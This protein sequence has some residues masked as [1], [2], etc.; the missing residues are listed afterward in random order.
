MDL[1]EDEKGLERKRFGQSP[2]GFLAYQ[3]FHLRFPLLVM[4]VLITIGLSYSATNLRVG[5]GF[6]KMV[7]VNHE[8]MS[9]YFK[10]R[11]IFG[12]ANKIQVAVVARDDN[13]FTAEFFE[14]LKGV[15]EEIFY[16]PG[17]S[18]TTVTSLY[19]PN[20]LFLEVVE[21]GFRAERL[22]TNKFKPTQEH[23]DTLKNKVAKS[24]WHGRIVAKDFSGAMV[25]AS[26]LETNPETGEPLDPQEISEI[27]EQIR[28]KYENENLSVH[29]IGF[30]KSIGDIAKGAEGVVAFFA[31]A[32]LITALLL[33]WYSGS[34]MLAWWALVCAMVPVVWLLGILPLLDMV[35]DPMSILVPFLIFSIGVSHAVQMTNAWKLETLHG[36][37]GV[38]ASRN[39]FMKLFIPGALALLANALGFMVIAVVDIQI[40]RELVFTATIGVSLMILTNK[41]L[42]PIL[43]SYMKINA[44]QAQKMTGKESALDWLWEK[45]GPIVVRGPVPIFIIVGGILV[46]M[47]GLWKAQDLHI[48]DLGQG[49]PELRPEARYNQDVEAITSRFTTGIDVLQI[50]P[51]AKG[52]DES[53]CLQQEVMDTLDRFEFQMRQYDGVQSVRG[54]ASFA[55]SV[56]QA[57]SE[58]NLKWRVM[59]DNAPQIAQ[60]IA[61]ST[62]IG[63][64]LFDKKCESLVVSIYTD[65]H[66]ATTIEELVGHVKAFKQANDSELIEFQLASG[67]VGVMAATNE[68]V[69]ASDKWVNLAL[70]V[71]VALLCLLEFKSIRIVVAIVLPLGI[72][73]LLCNALMAALDIGL[74]VNT[75]PVVALGVG[76]GVDYG[77]YLFSVIKHEIEERGRSLQE[78]FVMSLKQRGMSSLFTAVMMTVSVITWYFSD[79]KFQADMGILLAFMFLVNAFGAILLAPAL[80]AYLLKVKPKNSKKKKKGKKA[81]KA[82]H[83]DEATPEVESVTA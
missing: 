65:N 73:V 78:A 41:M 58:N 4:C 10:Y 68:V 42:L 50:I 38:T 61:F 5:A 19:S 77:I 75:L 56:N 21:D 67:N 8:Y 81:D 40:V 71:S 35:L 57:Y 52:A 49:V 26:L 18:R 31:I 33:Y 53:P 70:F 29:I 23:F 36:A 2:I 1:L 72:S 48:G 46:A 24:N 12:G 37:D 27:L 69:E 11:D 13:M 79:L 51:V 9:T 3:I 62:R 59:P 74:K 55:R 6:E 16:T 14:T 25:S 39:C 32:F 54:P 82:E 44:E 30:S 20:V 17:I 43:L 28:Q 47:G 64:T 45:M 15:H 63:Y 83:A 66:E 76:V 80:A 34:L 7:P 60:S 22:L